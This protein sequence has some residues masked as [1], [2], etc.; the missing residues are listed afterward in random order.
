MTLCLCKSSLSSVFLNDV[1]DT[2]IKTAVTRAE[3]LSF[4]EVNFV[5]MRSAFSS[6]V[7]DN[8]KMVPKSHAALELAGDQIAVAQIIIGLA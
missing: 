2:D 5:P 4:F 8:N 1:E 6:L 3:L 7:R